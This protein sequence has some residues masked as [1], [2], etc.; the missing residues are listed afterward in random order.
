MPTAR[1][2]RLVWAMR[3][4]EDG[5]ADSVDQIIFARHDW[6]FHCGIHYA[7]PGAPERAHITARAEGGSD[8]PDNLHLLCRLCHVQSEML[9][10]DD[11][12]EWFRAPSWRSALEVAGLDDL[13]T[14]AEL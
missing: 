13:I 4:V 12:W 10:G 7:M 14:K 2:I 1:T 6:C 9:D 5:K 8:S 3:L 11:Y